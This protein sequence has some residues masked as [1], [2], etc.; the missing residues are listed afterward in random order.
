MNQIKVKGGVI[1]VRNPSVP[2]KLRLLAKLGLNPAAIDQ[3]MTFDMLA[4][5]VEAISP[6]ISRVEVGEVTSWDDFI[7]NE[8]NMTSVIEVVSSV[9][10][11]PNKD[12]TKKR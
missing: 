1:E 12:K 9:L 4:T 10:N 5:A 11:P 7:N 2:E 3:Q 8:D 6:L